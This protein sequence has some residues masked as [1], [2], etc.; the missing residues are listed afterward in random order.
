MTP[1]YRS[2]VLLHPRVR[3]IQEADGLVTIDWM[4]ADGLLAR[5]IAVPSLAWQ[6][7]AVS[8]RLEDKAQVAA[9]RAS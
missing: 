3:R 2:E 7:A 1:D 8:L 9:G 4:G 5:L 6:S